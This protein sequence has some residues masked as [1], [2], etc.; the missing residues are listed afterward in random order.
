MKIV[1]TLIVLLAMA[2]G[3]NMYASFE[4]RDRLETALVLL[5]ERITSN[6]TTIEEIEEYIVD[7]TIDFESMQHIMMDNISGVAKSLEKHKHKPVYIDKPEVPVVKITTEPA[8]VIKTPTLKRTF[9]PET[10]LHVPNLPIKKDTSWIEKTATCPRA[11]NKLNKFIED[12]NIRKDYKFVVQYDVVDNH[13]SNIRFDNTLPNSLKFAV[14][15]YLN[16]FTLT[17][18]VNDCKIMI[19]VLEN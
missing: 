2:V 10:Q 6:V 15:K 5:D 3:I 19:K 11:N 1:T 7:S 18:N 9:D 16:T 14:T 17:G 8:P 12:I 4:E 13:I